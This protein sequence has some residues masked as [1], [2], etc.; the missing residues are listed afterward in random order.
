LE[1]FIR[2]LPGGL[3]SKF[4]T[5]RANIGQRLTLR[6]PSGAFGL[7]ENGNRPRF[8]V[9]GG[10]G[11]SPILSMVRHM[12]RERH[13]QPATLLFGVTHEHEL[14]YHQE[15]IALEKEMPNLEVHVSVMQAGNDWAGQRGT[16]VDT[17][18]Q[19]LDAAK[20]EILRKQLDVAI[21]SPDIY[22]CGPPGMIEATM[23]VGSSHGI[24]E[25]QI[26]MEKFLASG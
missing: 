5:T 10:T 7:H 22:L 13:P 24:P 15:L 19:Q 3:F 11:L 18:R 16:V 20:V 2:L 23:A 17:L 21:V 12:G 6:G 8:F 26:Y 14:F 1:F 9:S 4:L 25:S